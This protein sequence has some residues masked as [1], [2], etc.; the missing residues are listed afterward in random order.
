M[1][2]LAGGCIADSASRKYILQ[3][4]SEVTADPW[5]LGSLGVPALWKGGWGPGV[6]ERYLL[7]QMGVMT[8]NNRRLVITIAVRPSDG[9]FATGEAHASALVHWLLNRA[10]ASAEQPTKC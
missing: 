10:G 4:M 5:G 9:K 3:L 8:I 6:D 7:R 1:A 2:A